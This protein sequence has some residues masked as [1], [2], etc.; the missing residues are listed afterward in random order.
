MAEG[1]ARAPACTRKGA[2][3]GL[4][5]FHLSDNTPAESLRPRLALTK[6]DNLD[7]SHFCLFWFWNDESIFN[8]RIF[9]PG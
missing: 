5:I 1:P 7:I 6:H 2:A 4:P 3:D 8:N 9:L